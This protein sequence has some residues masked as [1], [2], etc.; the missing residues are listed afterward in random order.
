MRTLKVLVEI[1]EEN[2]GGGY[3]EDRIDEKGCVLQ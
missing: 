2:Y 1:T 3:A